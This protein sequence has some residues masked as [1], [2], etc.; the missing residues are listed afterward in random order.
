[1]LLIQSVSAIPKKI[2]NPRYC[3][4]LCRRL[5]NIQRSRHNKVNLELCF[6][7][8]PSSGTT[9]RKYL[10]KQPESN[11]RFRYV[12]YSNQTNC[13]ASINTLQAKQ[14]NERLSKAANLYDGWF[15]RNVE[16]LDLS[17]TTSRNSSVEKLTGMV[18]HKH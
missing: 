4:I 3:L 13:V 7:P 2:V 12:G 5:L 15:S 18:L 11:K 9:Y 1:M 6:L 14:F 8:L 16:N 10:N 17:P